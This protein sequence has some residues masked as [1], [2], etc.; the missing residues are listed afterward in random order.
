M[1]TQAIAFS[2]IGV[3]HQ[4]ERDLRGEAIDGD[5]L[6]DATGREGEPREKRRGGHRAVGHRPAIGDVLRDLD[7]GGVRPPEQLIPREAPLF[8]AGLDLH[9]RLGGPG[10]ARE[11]SRQ[12]SAT[13][14]VAA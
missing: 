4:V 6:D 9:R 10:E 3:E 14:F 12:P 2:A 5:R 7:G 13:I 8:R 11:E 1:A